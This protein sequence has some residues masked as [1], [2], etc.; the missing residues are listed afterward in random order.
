MIFEVRVLELLSII[1]SKELA[2]REKDR[3][4]LPETLLAKTVLIEFQVFQIDYASCLIVQLA[5]LKSL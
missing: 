2:D 3:A 1:A 4:I 5:A